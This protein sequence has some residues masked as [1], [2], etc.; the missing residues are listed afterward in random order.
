MTEQ[1]EKK[2]E[3]PAPPVHQE[4]PLGTRLPSETVI[5]PSIFRKKIGNY[6]PGGIRP[7]SLA[8]FRGR[9]KDESVRFNPQF[10][11]HFLHLLR[12]EVPA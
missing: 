12:Y 9:G 5:E 7:A 11:D 10:V 6:S 4:I 8:F 1:Q 3:A 2:D